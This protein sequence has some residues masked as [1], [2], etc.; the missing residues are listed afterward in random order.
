MPLPTTTVT[1]GT[2]LTINTLNDGR[3]VDADSASMALS[4]ENV[5]L[6]GA[7]TETAPATDTASSG[8]NGR[9]QRIAQ[10][11]TSMLA[12][13]PSARGQVTGANSLSV[14][15][16]SDTKF[17]VTEADGDNA[18]IGAK[19]DAAYA[20]SGGSSVIA[21]L[22]GLYA[23]MIAATPAGTNNIGKISAED[24]LSTVNPTVT[25]SPYAVNKVVGGKLTFTGCA[26]SGA[27]A[28][29]GWIDSVRIQ[30]KSVQTVPVTIHLFNADPTNTTIA[31]FVALTTTPINAADWSKYIGAVTLAWT[32]GG[33]AAIAEAT[34]GLPKRFKLAGTS[35]YAYAVAAGALQPTSTADFTFEL[36]GTPN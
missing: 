28:G 17:P 7:L 34:A 33:G 5:A 29:S 3:R 18:A 12:I 22:K 6:L 20:G 19:A 1:P 13:L 36:I 16:N 23:A 15:P 14:V 4:I 9:L 21:A 10:R 31:D 27:S 25:A 24:F 8:A 30:S 35:I 26:R 11:L 2:G 32:S